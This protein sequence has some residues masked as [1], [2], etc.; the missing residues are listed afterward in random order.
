[1]KT[2][3]SI[4]IYSGVPDQEVLQTIIHEVLHAIHDDLQLDC[5]KEAAGHKDLDRV[6]LAM[7]DVLTRNGWLRV[8][9]G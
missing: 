2:G 3:R 5:F 7:A 1:M 8:G 4:R 6:A 9:E